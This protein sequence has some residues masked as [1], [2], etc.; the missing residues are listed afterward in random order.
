MEIIEQFTCGK[1]GDAAKN[2]DKI[3]ATPHFIA[4]LDGVTA[5]SCPE[6]DGRK[7][8]RFAV[9]AAEDCIRGWPED[10]GG[11][12]AIEALS[13]ALQ[14]AMAPHV[15][16]GNTGDT[17]AFVLAVYSVARQE[18]WRLGDV[19]FMLD[20]AVS[21]GG[22]DYDRITSE[23]RALMLEIALR[24]G[25]TLESFAEDDP[26]R[27]LIAP[28]L[29]GQHNFANASGPYGYGVIDGRAVPREYI[30]I[31]PV[32][33]VEIVLA[34]DGYPEVCATLE[35]SEARLAEILKED[36]MQFRLHKS[37][38]G[39]QAGQVSFDDRSYIRFRP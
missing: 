9:D 4:V 32:E 16:P 29:A 33:V 25:R 12:E 8:G 21:D 19:A 24:Q 11:L 38:K 15:P 30:D 34:S 36:P 7:G 27:A 14:A 28:L 5:K 18:I 13:A 31:V 23:A 3:I 37:T 1:L 10:I 22:K 20:G 2:E 26:G 39:L 6:I 35:E 17:P